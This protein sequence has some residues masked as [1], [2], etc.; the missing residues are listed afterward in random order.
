GFEAASR[1][2]AHVQMVESNPKAAAALR[3]LRTKLKA[4]AVRVHVGDSLK[5]AKRTDHPYDLVMLDPPFERGWL[6][7][8]WP[9]IPTLLEPSGLLYV[10]S[11]APV[12]DV[13]PFELL[14]ASRAG[15]VHFQLLKFAATQK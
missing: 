1:G 7:R 12:R 8:L 13:A 3:A 2:V 9:L 6:E 14:R 15:H 11:E 5:V 4:D 10:E